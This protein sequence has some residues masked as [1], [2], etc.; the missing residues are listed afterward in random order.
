MHAYHWIHTHGIKEFHQH[1]KALIFFK[2]C[3]VVKDLGVSGKFKAVRIGNSTL[4]DLS[5][6]KFVSPVWERC[7]GL[8]LEVLKPSGCPLQLS[9]LDQKLILEEGSLNMKFSWKLYS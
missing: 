4:T 5:L 2:A 9:C 8:I 6:K 1:N 3:R 7:F